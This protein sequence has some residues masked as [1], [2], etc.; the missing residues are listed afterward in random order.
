MSTIIKNTV[1]NIKDSASNF[2][3]FIV[4]YN[5]IQLGMAFIISTQINRLASDFIDNIISP[6]IER[7]VSNDD[8][9]LR[10][11]KLNIFGIE[12]EIGNFVTSILKFVLLLI[13]LYYIFKITGAKK[14]PLTIGTNLTPKT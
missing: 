2:T 1:E 6:I 7:F 12:F 10:R 5:I 9:D 11:K 14:I 8:V 13:I 4:S 3:E